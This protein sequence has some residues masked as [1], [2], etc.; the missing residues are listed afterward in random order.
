M[1]SSQSGGDGG[2]GTGR[3]L[4]VHV[5]SLDALENALKT[6]ERDLTA[7]I[8]EMRSAVRN[9][10]ARWGASTASRQAHD[11]FDRRFARATEGLAASAAELKRAVADLRELAHSAE[12]RAVAIID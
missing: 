4:V 5:A 12:V 11:D 8:E 9:R 2:G 6:A 1:A 10:I 3:R 7:E